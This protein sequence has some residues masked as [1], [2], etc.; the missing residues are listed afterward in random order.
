V[1]VDDM[2][3]QHRNFLFAPKAG[4]VAVA[5]GKGIEAAFRGLGARIVSGQGTMNPSVEELVR[6]I[7]EITTK[8]VIILP[9]D[10]NV[11]LA[12]YRAVELARKPAQVVS[13]RSIPEG[14]SSLVVFD[15][16]RDMEENSREM[17]EAVKGMRSGKVARAVRHGDYGK[18]KVRRG[19]YIGLGDGRPLSSNPSPE[20]AALKLVEKLLTPDSQLVMLYY[21]AG[22]KGQRAKRLGQEVKERYPDLEVQVYYGGQPHYSYLVGIS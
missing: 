7:D 9:N 12:A 6:V 19:E 10:P 2:K 3:V 18:I 8:E 21:G 16:E 20:G 11:V 4:V 22:V 17:A 1:K 15:P 13:T 5:E 14:I